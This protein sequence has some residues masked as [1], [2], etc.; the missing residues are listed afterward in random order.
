MPILASTSSN[1]SY[2]SLSSPPPPSPSA[3]TAH[4]NDF[5]EPEGHIL[6]LSILGVDDDG[7]SETSS[8]ERTPGEHI[9]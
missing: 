3:L 8:L 2:L 4:I 6:D 1:N 9:D 5:P 7:S